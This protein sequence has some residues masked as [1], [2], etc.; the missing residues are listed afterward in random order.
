MCCM[1]L[2]LQPAAM[3]TTQFDRPVCLENPEIEF[4]GQ[5]MGRPQLSMNWVVVTDED[6][7]RHLRMRWTGRKG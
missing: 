4:N 6:G 7:K 5:V 1:D 3:A 2:M